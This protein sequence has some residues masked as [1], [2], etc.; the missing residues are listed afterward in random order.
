[1]SQITSKVDILIKQSNFGDLVKKL[2]D[3]SKIGDVVKIKIDPDNTLIYSMVGEGVILAFKSY[4]L[5]TD[6]YFDT[7]GFGDNLNLIVSGSKRFVKNLSFIKNELPI[8]VNLSYRENDEGEGNVRFIQIKNGKFKI[9]QS[10]GE[11]SEIRDINKKSLAQKLN[12]KDKQWSFNISNSDF[13]DIK[14]L[15]NINSEG[16]TLSINVDKDGVVIISEQ[17]VW[18]LEVDNVGVSNKN[19]IFSKTF[20]GNINNNETIEFHVF[21]NFILNKDKESDLMISFEQTFED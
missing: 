2:E 11:E 7:K 10:C 13:D 19:I 18:D 14:K 17:S 20:L 4:L 12:L 8:K 15:S 16:K 9:G 6:E 21:E 1:M 5:K 3:L